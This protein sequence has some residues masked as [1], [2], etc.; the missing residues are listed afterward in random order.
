MKLVSFLYSP[1]SLCEK[2]ISEQYIFLNIALIHHI[3][4][5]PATLDSAIKINY[6]NV[7]DDKRYCIA[8][9]V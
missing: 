2:K 7:A 9:S 5:L 4:N 3:Y 1:L 6:R 8:Q